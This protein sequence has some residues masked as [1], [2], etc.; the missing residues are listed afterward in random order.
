MNQV[1][2][3]GKI[4]TE[5]DFNFILNSKKKS[6]ALFYLE[7]LDGEKIRILGYDNIAD[8]CYSK[9]NSKMNIFVYGLLNKDGVEIKKLIIV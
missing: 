9:L 5:V 1:F 2:L 4:I 7:T 3:I 8:Y 6:I